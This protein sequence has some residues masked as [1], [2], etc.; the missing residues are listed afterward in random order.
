LR[1][2]TLF[3]VVS[4]ITASN[5]TVASAVEQTHVSS[6]DKFRQMEGILPTPNNYRAASGEP[7]Q[8]YC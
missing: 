7:G 3:S 4:F 5:Q 6:V 8:D 1:Y 2:L